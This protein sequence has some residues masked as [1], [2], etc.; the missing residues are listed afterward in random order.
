M[1]SSWTQKK[2]ENNKWEVGSHFLDISEINHTHRQ[3]H[4]TVTMQAWVAWQLQPRL[5]C[6]HAWALAH[7]NK[8]LACKVKHICTHRHTHLYKVSGLT[9]Q[10][11]KLTVITCWP[12]GCVNQT[13][14]ALFAHMTIMW[15]VSHV[16]RFLQIFL[17]VF[18]IWSFTHQKF[19]CN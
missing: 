3:K 16:N 1:V 14:T 13:S 5:L 8:A 6:I 2:F 7:K 15:D 17:Q 12:N 19:F 18:W 10:I 11:L 4:L 9:A